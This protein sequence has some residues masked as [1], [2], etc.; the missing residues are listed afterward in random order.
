MP[1]TTLA[2][3]P[4]VTISGIK[5]NVDRGFAN[6][7]RIFIKPNG[8]KLSQNNKIVLKFESN[9]KEET[10]INYNNLIISNQAGVSIVLDIIMSW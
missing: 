7:I 1:E 10:D 2:I 4:P 6:Q 8:E 9:N 3:H 5:F